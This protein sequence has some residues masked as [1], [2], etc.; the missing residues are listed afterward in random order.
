MTS[1]QEKQYEEAKSYFRNLILERIEEEGI[2]K[3][4]MIVLQGLTKLRQIANHPRMVDANYEGDS[5][6]WRRI[7]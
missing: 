7:N 6:T 3:S 1:D 4:Q 2:A 5:Q